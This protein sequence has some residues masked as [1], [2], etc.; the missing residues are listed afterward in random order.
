MA[1]SAP[2]TAGDDG[3]PARRG[4]LR[5]RRRGKTPGK[6]GRIAQMRQ[7]YAMTRRSDPAVT[8]WMV[9]VVAG[10]MVLA[11]AIGLAWGHPVYTSFLG[12]PIAVMLAM[13]V[14]A[15][16]AERAAYG[17]IEG[18]P[19]AAG[20]ALRS[21]RRGWT[22]EEEPVAIDPRTQDTVF[23]AVGR[24]GVVLVGDGPPHRIGKLL[25]M[26]RRKVA[27]VLPTVPVHVIQAGAGEG[28]VP[29]PKVGRR[30]MKLKPK[31]NKAE[32]AEVQKRLR[33]LGGL[34][35]PIPRGVDPMRAR[36][37]RKMMRGGR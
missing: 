36:P 21:L 28:Q 15:R 31:L 6:T 7:I 29:L 22:V 12:L 33:A 11:L 25:E 14:L 18:T 27:R 4:L 13:L 19:G 37:D 3:S 34:R 24:P 2:S 20:A 26:E 10:V 5:R 9:L 35:P 1:R 32:I 8:W 16:R 17:Q 30:V 23:R